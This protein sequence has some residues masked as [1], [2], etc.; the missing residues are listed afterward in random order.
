VLGEGGYVVAP[1]KFLTRLR[2]LCT[3]EG[4]LLI[5]DEVQTGFGRTGEWFASVHSGIKPDIITM[6]KG[7][8][9]GF[10]LSA[11]GSTTEI[12]SAWP[13]GAH[14]TTFGGNPVS[15]AA[16]IATIDTIERDSLLENAR[17]VGEA[18]L[19][20]LNVMKTRIPAIGDVRGKGFM[21]GVELARSDG[22][23][24]A[25]LAEAVIKRAIDKG[26]I[27]VECGTH[28]NIIRLMPPLIV[29]ATEM[30]DALDIIEEALVG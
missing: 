25:E 26:L 5:A 20:R 10:P 19:K 11:V 12:M 14:G 28:K 13:K 3:K 17:V 29:T 24:D 16:S 22:S 21:I 1:S 15:C 18:A 8:A 27:L 6:G 2:E 9:S 23:P 30:T 7:M 4:I